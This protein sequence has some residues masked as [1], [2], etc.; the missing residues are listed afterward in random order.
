ME[1]LVPAPRP[2]VGPGHLFLSPPSPLRPQTP[3]RGA[4][5]REVPPRGGRGGRRRRHAGGGRGGKAGQG[6]GGGPGGL[7]PGVDGLGGPGARRVRGRRARAVG[8]VGAGAADGGGGV[9]GV[10]SGGAASVR[11]P[12]PRPS[13]GGLDGGRAVPLDPNLGATGPAPGPRR[14][15]AHGLGPVVRVSVDVP[16]PRALAS[17]VAFPSGPIAPRGAGGTFRAKVR[18]RSGVGGVAEGRGAEREGGAGECRP[19]RPGVG[20]GG[21]RHGGVQP[22]VR[23]GG[24]ASSSPPGR[25]LAPGP[26]R[27][28]RR[29]TQGRGRP[30]A[31]TVGADSRGGSHGSRVSPDGV[32][33]LRVHVPRDRGGLPQGGG[34]GAGH[35]DGPRDPPWPRDVSKRPASR[36]P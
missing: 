6:R 12:A 36:A 5:L 16:T 31:P 25:R 20:A 3:G 23:P 24:E 21:R 13:R 29:G 33:P 17:R 19:P 34:D 32:H 18:R 10:L 1:A 35:L 26:R 22:W 9:L 15:G 11:Q 8:G 2:G 14:H 28:L 7:G 30:V 4:G 27:G